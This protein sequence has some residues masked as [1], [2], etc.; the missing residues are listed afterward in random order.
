MMPGEAYTSHQDEYESRLQSRVKPATLFFE[1]SWSLGLGVARVVPT[2]HPSQHECSILNAR[3][4]LPP[5]IDGHTVSAAP[6][7]LPEY[8]LFELFTSADHGPRT[9]RD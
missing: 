1:A 4:V 9:D 3:L 7:G 2:H 6:P 8:S 5:L